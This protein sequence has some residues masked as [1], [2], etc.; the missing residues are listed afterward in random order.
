MR[1]S[2]AIEKVEKLIEST[3]F[4]LQIAKRSGHHKVTKS[5]DDFKTLVKELTEKGDV[6]SS[7]PI[8]RKYDVFKN[9]QVIKSLARFGLW[10]IK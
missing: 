8:P 7:Q 5:H 1:C 10:Q 4:D 6:F 2:Q 9:F 3:D